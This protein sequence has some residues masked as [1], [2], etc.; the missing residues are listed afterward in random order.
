MAA[1]NKPIF[2]TERLFVR[3]ASLDDVDMIHALWT[4]PRVMADVGF[5]QGLKIQHSQILDQIQRERGKVLDAVLIAALNTSHQ[6]IGQVR[7]R[8]P[9]EDGISETD[10]KFFPAFWGHNYGLEIKLGL[11]DYIFSH[12]DAQIIQ[13]TPSINNAASIKMQERA[14]GIRVGEGIF[15]FPDEMKSY[16]TPVPHFVYHIRREDWEKTQNQA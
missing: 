15:E 5:P 10:V 13:A 4:D 3:F 16:T 2:T 1:N 8:A 6:S 9:G 14:G 12:T 11:V 7:M